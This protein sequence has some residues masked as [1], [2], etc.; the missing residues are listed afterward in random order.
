MIVLVPGYRFRLMLENPDAG[1][2]LVDTI[3]TDFLEKRAADAED[4]PQLYSEVLRFVGVGGKRLRPTFC[5]LGFEA[6]GGQVGPEIAAAA[7]SLELLH[8]F[9]LMHDDVMDESPMRRGAPATHISMA[10]LP[11]A[12]GP[13]SARFGT[14]AAI[15]A[16]DL[17]M[18]L[19]DVLWDRAMTH[20]PTTRQ[21]GTTEY[22]LMREEVVAGQFLDLITAASGHATA[23]Q[24]RRI[25]ILKSGRYTVERPLLIGAALADANTDVAEALRAYGAPIGEAFQLRDDILGVFG[26]PSVTGKDAFG[27]LREG[28]QTL[29]ITE[30]RSRSSASELS[31]LESSIGRPD[32][33]DAD[34]QQLRQLI[35][36]TGA[37]DHVTKTIEGLLADALQVLESSSI[38][39]AARGGLSELAYTA[40]IRDL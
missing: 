25:S 28:K 27:D 6:G 17:A 7:A 35:R 36:D 39:D 19:A 22:L 32:L 10:D 1:R 8:A 13:G 9:A 40:T 34:A 16:G 4:A 20:F 33:S 23:E 24:A 38:S 14:S 18:T 29:L 15:L 37:F 21:K 5:L 30:A 26:D 11:E 2:E 31:F 12:Q 3:L